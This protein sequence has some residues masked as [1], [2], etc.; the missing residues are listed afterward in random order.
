MQFHYVVVYDSDTKSWG[1][2]D[3][4]SGYLP[5][6]RVWDENAYPGW[7]HPDPDGHPREY[8]IDERAFTML[9]TLASIWPEVDHGDY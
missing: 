7:F 5:D 3:D 9:R 1:V 6:G 8:V 2:I 4:D